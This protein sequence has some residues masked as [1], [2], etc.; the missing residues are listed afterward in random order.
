MNWAAVALAVVLAVVLAALVW[1]RLA[2]ARSRLR[3]RSAVAEAAQRLRQLY[4]VP[5]LETRRPGESRAKRNDD[6]TTLSMNLANLQERLKSAGG[7]RGELEGVR[8]DADK[9]ERNNRK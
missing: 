4:T 6:L 1:R 7:D 5:P 8:R 2:L 9:F 3:A